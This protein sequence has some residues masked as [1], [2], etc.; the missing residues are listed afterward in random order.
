MCPGTQR[1][2]VDITETPS[3]AHIIIM[4]HPQ[5]GRAGFVCVTRGNTNLTG[6]NLIRRVK[7]G[8]VCAR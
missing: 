6:T 3:G 2:I 7:A 8:T 4:S 5:G 1:P